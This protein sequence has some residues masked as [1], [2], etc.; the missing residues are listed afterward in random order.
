MAAAMT[1]P[2]HPQLRELWEE[3]R[4]A[5]PPQVSG[6]RRRHARYHHIAPLVLIY[7]GLFL[8]GYGTTA[9]YLLVSR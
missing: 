7:G 3:Q 4:N 8:S 9:T 2:V 5:A 1:L 6:R